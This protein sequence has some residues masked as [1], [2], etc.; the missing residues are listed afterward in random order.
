MISFRPREYVRPLPVLQVI[1]LI[2]IL[3]VTLS[4]F[5][6]LSLHFNFESELNVSVPTASSSVEARLA[7]EEIVVN[8]LKDGEIV[9]NQ[10]HVSLG[11]LSD[12]LT[13]TSQ[14]YPSQPVTVRADQKTYHENVIRV[15][16]ACAKAKIWNIS[17][18]T[19]KEG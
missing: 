3:F 16:D 7:P 5:M 2:D 9:V 10:K 1:P 15:L 6:A 17:F 11:Q 4:F 18:A 19:S 13:K 14:L 12:I 8:V